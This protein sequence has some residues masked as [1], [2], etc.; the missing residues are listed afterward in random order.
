MKIGIAAIGRLKNGPERE[1]YDRYAKRAEVSGRQI[2]MGPFSLIEL[3]ESKAGNVQVRQQQEGQGVL[4]KIQDQ[5]VLIILDEKGKNLTSRAFSDKL[6]DYRDL[7]RDS[8]YF[9]IGGPDGLS[10]EIKSKADLSISFGAMTLP[11]GIVRILLAE[12]LYRA[13]TIA[14]GHPYHRD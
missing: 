14:S 3:N 6:I 5:A 10:A 7:G 8:V 13:I 9:I 12:Q 2:S 4:N 1:L 11:H